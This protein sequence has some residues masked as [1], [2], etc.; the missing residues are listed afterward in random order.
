VMVAAE[1]ACTVVDDDAIAA[2]RHG[3][4]ERNAARR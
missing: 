1:H 3:G 2:D 4:D